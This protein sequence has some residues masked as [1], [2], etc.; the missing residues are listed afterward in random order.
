MPKAT[1]SPFRQA[2]P[3][4]TKWPVVAANPSRHGSWFYFPKAKHCR[5]EDGEMIV[6]TREG[7]PL[8]AFRPLTPDDS[9][10]IAAEP[11]GDPVTAG[12]RLHDQHRPPALDAG[13]FMPGDIS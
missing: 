9:D 6:V 8:I 2:W 10:E 3:H 11:R 5:F 4:P 13:I 7:H 12:T 1:P